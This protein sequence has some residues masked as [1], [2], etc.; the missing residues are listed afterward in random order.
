MI[1]LCDLYSAIHFGALENIFTFNH[2]HFPD[3]SPPVSQVNPYHVKNYDQKEKYHHETDSI[4]LVVHTGPIFTV[5]FLHWLTCYYR[6]CVCSFYKNSV[7]YQD[8]ILSRL[9]NVSKISRN[10][11]VTCN[12]HFKRFFCSTVQMYFQNSFRS[13]YLSL[14]RNALS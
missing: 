14:E 9:P 13:V 5:S 1:D 6:S 10:E 11:T 4:F 2:L 12:V 8:K 7:V 3:L